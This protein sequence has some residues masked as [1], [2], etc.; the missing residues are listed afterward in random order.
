LQFYDPQQPFNLL[1]RLLGFLLCHRQLVPLIR[2]L[3][4]DH[5]QL[6]LMDRALLSCPLCKRLSVLHHCHYVMFYLPYLL[7]LLCVKNLVMNHLT[8]SEIHPYA[9]ALLYSFLLK[10]L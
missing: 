5:L 1:S 8:A 2:N 7:P 10:P 6:A 3:I 4:K 9:L